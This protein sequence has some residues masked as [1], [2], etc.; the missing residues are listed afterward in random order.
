MSG[1]TPILPQPPRAYDMRNEAE[2]RAAIMRLFAAFFRRGADIEL[3]TERIVLR[4]PNGA[5]FALIVADN[6]ALGTEPL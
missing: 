2:T 6:G 1:A 4:S 5:R 3:V